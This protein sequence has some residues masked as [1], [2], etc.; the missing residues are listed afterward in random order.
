MLDDG[1][2][3]ALAGTTTLEEVFRVVSLKDS[4]L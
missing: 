1:L 2:E 4:H 3:K